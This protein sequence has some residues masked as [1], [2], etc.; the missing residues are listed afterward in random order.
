MKTR[1]KI[2]ELLKENPGM[3]IPELAEKTG[4]TAKG[5]EWNLAKLKQE[6]VIARI[7]PDRGGHWEITKK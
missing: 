3:S 7:G 4:L 1:V 5:I 2:L 6:G